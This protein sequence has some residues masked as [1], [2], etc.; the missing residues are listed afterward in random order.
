MGFHGRHCLLPS[1]FLLLSYSS[2]LL[3][4]VVHHAHIPFE[5]HAVYQSTSLTAHTHTLQDGYY[6]STLNHLYIV[7]NLITLRDE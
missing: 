5:I 7:Y 6:S 4:F 3:L 2:S 1:Y